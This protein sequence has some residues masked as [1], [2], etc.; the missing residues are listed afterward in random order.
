MRIVGSSKEAESA[1]GQQGLFSPSQTNL[2][3]V[4]TGNVSLLTKAVY[5]KKKDR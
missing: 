4:K 1:D 5:E 3:N 2:H